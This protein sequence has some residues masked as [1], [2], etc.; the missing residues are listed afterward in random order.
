MQGLA[1]LSRV[2]VKYPYIGG[3]KWNFM[4][5][6]DIPTASDPRYVYLRRL[7][8][9]QTPWFAL[10]LHFIYETDEDRDPHDHPF[11]FWSMILRGEYQ[12][13]VYPWVAQQDFRSFTQHHRRLSLHHMPLLS[14]HRIMQASDGLMTLV[15]CGRKQRDWGF[16]TPDGFLG[17]REYNRLKYDTE[18]L[19]ADPELDEFA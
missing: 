3:T 13:I 7:R 10:Y 6:A 2:P 16:Y 9:F 4:K 18:Y 5:W 8:I 17:W 1:K 15:F 11:S 14:A 12:E 19:R